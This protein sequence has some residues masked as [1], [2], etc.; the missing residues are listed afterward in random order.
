LSEETT[1]WL[2]IVCIV[3]GAI[4]IF[5]WIVPGIKI[6]AIGIIPFIVGIVAL[7][8]H[9]RKIKVECDTDVEE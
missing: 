6:A 2:Y 8:F 7:F 1:F 3:L 9:H 4:L 5:N